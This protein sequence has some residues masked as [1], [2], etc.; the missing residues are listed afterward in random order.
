[1]V[2][3]RKYQIK[4]TL[5]TRVFALVEKRKKP[6]LYKRGKQ[7][8]KEKIDVD[9]NTIFTQWNKEDFYNDFS[10]KY[11]HKYD[12]V[13][14]WFTKTMPDYS[15]IIDIAE[16][17][18]VSVDYLIGKTDIES[19]ITADLASN[20]TGL[21]I[22]SINLL[23]EYYQEGHQWQLNT[24][25]ALNFLLEREETANILTNMYYYFFGNYTHTGN[26]EKTVSL[27]DE[28]KDGVELIISD[29]QRPVFMSAIINDL[30]SFYERYVKDNPQYEN[31]GKNTEENYV[32]RCVNGRLGTK[33]ERLNSVRDEIKRNMESNEKNLDKY[34]KSKNNSAIEMYRSLIEYN[35]KC[36]KIVED[37]IKN[38]R[39]S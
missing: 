31:Y 11:G 20:Y 36:L 3:K 8:G 5:R 38:C 16:Y 10:Q 24:I 13:K 15:E 14:A 26:G 29:M 30:T 34:N 35:M 19:T 21:E 18:S 2:S 9:G 12:T 32:M 39:T 37:K 23:N 1:M 27:M 25:D 22:H 6:A 17:F 28:N 7:K 33:L 4:E